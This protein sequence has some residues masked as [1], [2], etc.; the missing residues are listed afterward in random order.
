MPHKASENNTCSG[1]V[2]PW[3]GKGVESLSAL[4]QSVPRALGGAR[5]GEGSKW[6]RWQGTWG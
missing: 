3:A 4:F 1:G 2:L 6:G 5:L